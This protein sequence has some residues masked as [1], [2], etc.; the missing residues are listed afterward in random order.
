[1][2]LILNVGELADG[3]GGY[4]CLSGQAAVFV[5]EWGRHHERWGEGRVVDVTLLLASFVIW[6]EGEKR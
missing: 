3:L 2:C 6:D 1:M 4:V 5:G